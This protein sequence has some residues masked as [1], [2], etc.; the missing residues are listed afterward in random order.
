MRRVSPVRFFDEAM[1][2]LARWMSERYVAPLATVL[3]VLSPPRVASEEIDPEQ[4]GTVEGSPLREPPVPATLADYRGGAELLEAIGGGSGAFILRPAPEDEQVAAV[5][6]VGACLARGRRAIVVVPEAAPVPATATALR[7]AFGERV[8]LY[9]G[10]AKRQRYRTWLDVQAGA[11]DVGWAPA[12]RCSRAGAEPRPPSISR[13]SHPASR[14]SGAVLPRPD[15]ALARGRI[16]GA[17]VVLVDEPFDGDGGA[18]PGGRDADRRRWPPVEDRSP[19]SRDGPPAGT[20][21]RRG[22]TRVPVSPLRATASPRSA[23]RAVNQRRALP[24][25]PAPRGGGPGFDVVARQRAVQ[26]LRRT[27]LRPASR[28]P[29]AGG[30]VGDPRGIGAVKRLVLIDVRDCRSRARSSWAA[31]RRA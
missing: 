3:G 7:T 21:A 9:L 4:T 6:A 10:G 24:V 16:A 14:G 22:E 30:G 1:L 29:G 18:P 23:G 26:A 12:P 15:V 5:H 31:R 13:E 17:T 20:G 19:G 11:F 8:C 2:Q 28:R 25:G 27:G